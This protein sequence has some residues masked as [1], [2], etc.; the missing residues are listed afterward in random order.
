MGATK[1]GSGSHGFGGS[2]AVRHDGEISVN[3]RAPSVVM[4]MSRYTYSST[5]RW[6]F[7]GST[8]VSPPS[9]VK[10]CSTRLMPVR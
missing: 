9:P 6:P 1:R 3:V 2:V 7:L 10:A 5:A 4:Y 8:I